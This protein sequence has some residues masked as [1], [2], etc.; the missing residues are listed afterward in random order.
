MK[1]RQQFLMI[2]DLFIF[3]RSWVGCL[4]IKT[5]VSDLWSSQSLNNMTAVRECVVPVHQ[6][7]EGEDGRV[8]GDLLLPQGTFDLFPVPRHHLVIIGALCEEKG[9]HGRRHV[10]NVGA[11]PKLALNT[12]VCVC[13]FVCVLTVAVDDRG[14]GWQG[15]LL[16]LWGNHGNG[17]FVYPRLCQVES[18]ELSRGGA[19]H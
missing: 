4:A 11:H 3:V 13:V 15:D 10:L 8:G 19:V 18:E 5:H 1:T 14:A 16:E 2:I 9:G 17:R 6:V 12:C 7:G